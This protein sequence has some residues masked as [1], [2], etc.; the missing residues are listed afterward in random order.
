MS[1]AYCQDRYEK[2]CEEDRTESPGTVPMVPPE[3][4]STK[5]NGARLRACAPAVSSSR[6]GTRPVQIRPR[7]GSWRS[8]FIAALETTGIVTVACQSASIARATYY[9]ERKTNKQFARD[10]REA[11]AKATDAIELE[12]RR[13]AVEGWNEPVFY[14]GNQVGTIRRYSDALLIALLTAHKPKK[15]RRLRETRPAVQ[16]DFA[17]APRDR[18]TVYS[19]IAAKIKRAQT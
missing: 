12:A 15:Y 11:I 9:R 2:Q 1:T 5:R 17:T 13:R 19:G 18:S 10:C 6:G 7:N 14:K 16:N 8:A 4:G 3:A